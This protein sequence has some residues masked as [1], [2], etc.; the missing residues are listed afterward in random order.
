[1]KEA[2]TMKIRDVLKLNEQDIPE[3]TG[4]LAAQLNRQILTPDPARKS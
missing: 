1:M 3:V 4:F 2:S